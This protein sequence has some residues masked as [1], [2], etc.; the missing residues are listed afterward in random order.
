MARGD[1]LARQW[2]II[3]TLLASNSGK[4]AAQ[5]ADELDCNARTVY[6]DLEA[7]QAAG[8]PLYTDRVDGKNLWSLLDTLKHHIPIPFTL[9]ELL[10]IYFSRD[11]LKFL[12][13]TVFHESL[14]SLFEKIKTTIPAESKKYLTTVQQ[15]FQ[16]TLKQ[17]KEYGKYREILNTIKDAA[18]NHKTVE[19]VYF[20]MGRRKEGRRKV[21][22]YRILFFNGTFYVIGFCH[23]RKDCRT[24]A[25]ERIKMLTTTDERFIV[26]EDFRLEDYM[27][28]GFGIIGGSPEKVKIWFSPDIAGYIKEKTWHES[29]VI[30]QQRDGSIIFEA[31]MAITEELVSWVIS[32][33]AK[34][35][36]LEPQALKDR[37]HAEVLAMLKASGESLKQEKQTSG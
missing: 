10:A 15:T 30:N 35:E 25:L 27:G 12:Q 1:Q 31:D 21:D 33:G 5:L 28:A 26:P 11:M 19:M 3:E 6:R 32:W 2:K 23:L 22:P 20:T 8:F 36:V 29:Q 16:V 14:E 9:T 24:F 17:F 7:L 34:A 18:L 37:I 4:S 13:N